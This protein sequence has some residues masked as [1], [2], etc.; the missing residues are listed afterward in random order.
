MF[1]RAPKLD[2]PTLERRVLR[3]DASGAQLVV[4]TDE[5][6]FEKAQVRVAFSE[7]WGGMSAGGYGSLNLATHVED[8]PDCV[9]TNRNLL[10]DALG[11]AGLPLVVPKQV[12]GD[13]VAVLS[14]ANVQSVDE[15]RTLVAKGADAMLIEPRGV[16]GIMN[17]ADCVPIVIVAP[18]GRF[19]I[20]HAGWRGVE[21][22]I[23]T[24]A[25]HKLMLGEPG[26]AVD[27]SH[28]NV[29]RGAYIHAECFEVG[30]DVRDLFIERLGRKVEHDE[31]HIDLGRALDIS[32]VKAGVDPTRIADVDR[33]TVCDN[34]H[35]FSYRA[36]GGVCG[37]HAALC[38]AV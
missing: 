6:L 19:C 29:Y 34:A 31:T 1:K 16:A 9:S 26:L 23:V 17:F 5:A 10:M 11:L 30:E 18:S 24:K 7:R 4:W 37:R 8:D 22:G 36:Q 25:L 14:R 3:Q 28:V 35:W 20:V 38:A 13:R 2:K 15:Y 12:H 33:C 21:N 32:L 27:A